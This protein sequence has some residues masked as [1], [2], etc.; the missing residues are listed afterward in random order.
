MDNKIIALLA[1]IIIVVVGVGVYG[2]STYTTS[3]ENGT[4]IIYAADSLASQLNATTAAFKQTHPNVN[5]QAQFM[6]SSAAIKQVTNLH[7]PADIVVSADYSL[8]D[9]QLIPTYA[10]WNLQYAHNDLVI[11]YTAK[12]KNSTELNSTNWYKIMNQ[13]NVTIGLSDPNSDPAGYRSVMMLQLADAYYNDGSIF[14]SLIGNN[15]AITSAKNGTGYVISSPSSANPTSKVIIRSDA[16]TL[17]PL[18]ESGTVDYAI[19]YKNIAAQQASSGVKYMPLPGELALNN[20]TYAPQYKGITLIQDSDSA[21][22]TQRTLVKLSAIVYGIT[23]LNN[24]P[25]KTL[26]TQYVQLLLSPQGTQIITNSFQDPISPA[27]ATNVS[28]N[29]PSSLKQYVTTM[30]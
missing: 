14:S 18:L 22:T 8:I 26:A 28:T 4:I 13:T 11:A 21:N 30:P 9:S 19:V 27:I 25:D 20:T 5:V 1:I 17:M 7:K 24:A 15:T 6:G 12:S 23:V 3:S 29:I 10:S 16:A 2:Y